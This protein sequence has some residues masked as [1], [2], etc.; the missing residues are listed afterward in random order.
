ML[1]LGVDDMFL[2]AYQ[3]GEIAHLSYIPFAVRIKSAIVILLVII[4]FRIAPE[5]V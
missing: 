1:G 5:N 4:L 2:T 3:F